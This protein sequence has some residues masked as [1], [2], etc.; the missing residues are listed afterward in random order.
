MFSFFNKKD[1][2]DEKKSETESKGFF[3]SLKETFS[4]TSKSLVSDIV[5][6]ANGKEEFDDLT[7]DDMEEMLIKADLGVSVS[8]YLIDNLRKQNIIKPSEIKS[9]LKDE[10]S[11]IL[12]NAGDN[13]LRYDENELNIYLI[14]GVNGVGKTTLIAKLANKFKKEG[15]KVLLAA[16]DTFRAAAVEQLQIWAQRINADIVCKHNAD[17]SSVVYEAIS[18]AKNEN[19]DVLIIDTAGRLQN[20]YNLME[21]LNK[22]KN[23]IIK[24]AKDSL[25]E[26]LLVLDASMGQNGINQAKTFFEVANLTGVAL[27]KLDGSSKGAVIISIA[28]DYKLPLK[29]IGVG[30]KVDD[31]KNFDKNEFI[32]SLFV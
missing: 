18:K 16:G 19:Y 12:D 6:Y 5:S 22:I 2:S 9:Y 28:K 31:I 1:N 3:S 4:K 17:P 10:F 14:T 7:L 26:S 15:K 29:L 21:E 32:E 20:K 27:T 13:K 11:Q 24:N 25:K 30:E 23:V 8:S